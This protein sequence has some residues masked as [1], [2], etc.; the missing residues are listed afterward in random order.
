MDVRE[1][2]TSSNCSS[3]EELVELLIVADSELNVARSDAALLVVTG[4]VSSKLKNLGAKILEDGRHVDW[5]TSTDSR[6]VST[7][8]Q[9]ASN[10]PNRELKSSLGRARCALSLLLSAS[11]FSFSRHV[12]ACVFVLFLMCVG[13]DVEEARQFAVVVKV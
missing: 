6:G 7:F 12:D 2:T 3:T 5:S 11:S 9:V 4:C 8:L 10:T 13:Y 1:Y